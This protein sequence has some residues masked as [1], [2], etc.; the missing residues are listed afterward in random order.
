MRLASDKGRLVACTATILAR[1]HCEVGL[2]WRELIGP[3]INIIHMIAITPRP[4]EYT[5]L[6]SVVEVH[7]HAIPTSS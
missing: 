2:G 1:L 3:G 7:V 5:V 6:G 4:G